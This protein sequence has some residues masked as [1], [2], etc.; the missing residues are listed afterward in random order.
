MLESPGQF[1]PAI[2]ALESAYHVKT[3]P[4]EMLRRT[5]KQPNSKSNLLAPWT[6]P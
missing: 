6:H 1:G 4:P 3:P 2:L 5:M